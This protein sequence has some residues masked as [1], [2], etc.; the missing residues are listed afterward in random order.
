MILSSPTKKMML[1][2]KKLSNNFVKAAKPCGLFVVLYGT[3]MLETLIIVLITILDQ[4]SKYLVN[5][6]LKDAAAIQVLPSVLSFRYH[7]NKGAAWGMLADHRWVFMI[8]STIAIVAIIGYLVWTRKKKDSK[9][10]RISLCFFAGG[11]IGNMIDRV[12]LG[13]VIDFLRFDF[14]DFPIFNVADSFIT[15]GAALMIL[16]LIL[17][18]ISDLR[19]KKHG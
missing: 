16:N 4:L 17:E 2:A 12:A 19:R 1:P 18:F 15:V 6:H 11:G 8:I 9:L 7:E 5:L 14:I 3:S 13:Y 10:F